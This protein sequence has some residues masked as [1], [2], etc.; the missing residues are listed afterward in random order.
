MGKPK[1]H[2]Q[3]RPAAREQPTF[4][5]SR[6]I[7]I[8][9]NLLKRAAGIRYRRLLGLPQG[10][11]G[12]I[13][14]L[15]ERAPRTLGDLAAGMGLDITQISRSVSNL[16]ERGLVTRSPNPFNNREV[17]IALTRRGEAANATIVAAGSQVNEVLLEAMPAS[18]R[19]ELAELLLRFTERAER[20]LASDQ[21]MDASDTGD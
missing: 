7:M 15:G 4:V 19:A 12:V 6:K 9:A 17:L 2:L 10:E 3:L 18:E 11:W 21:A 1:R 20:L 5:L 16:V 8:L 14:Q 13:A